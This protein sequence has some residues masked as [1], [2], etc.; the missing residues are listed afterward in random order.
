MT[1]L[2][3]ELIALVE[4]TFER[5][6]LLSPSDLDP[7]RELVGNG[8][9]DYALVAAAFHFVNRVADCLDVDPEALPER[10]RRFEPLRRLMVRLASLMMARMDLA[11]REYEKSYEDAVASIAAAIE[12]SGGPTS[13]E[14]FAPLRTRPK[15]IEALELALE[16]RDQRS[17]LDRATLARLQRT[18]EDALPA[19][20]IEAEGFHP[21]PADPV[22]AFAFVGTRYAYRTTADMIASLRAEGFDDLGIL[23]LAIAVADANQ[24][25]RLH[26][27]IGLAPELFYVFGRESERREPSSASAGAAL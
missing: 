17:V 25:A 3:R 13:T 5:P 20:R 22:E 27:L 26:R 19:S 8:A 1:A 4:K 2:E 9:L 12:E 15:V 16:E 11:N 7:L 10:L 24:W 14:A 6:K 23:D 18:V 21:R